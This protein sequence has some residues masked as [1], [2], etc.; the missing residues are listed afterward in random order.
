[1]EIKSIEGQVEIKNTRRLTMKKIRII[2]ILMLLVIVC[3]CEAN[4]IVFNVIR[5]PISDEIT[6]HSDLPDWPAVFLALVGVSF[7]ES[8]ILLIFLRDFRV[9]WACPY[10][11]AV[12]M[13]PG[14]LLLGKSGINASTSI[15]TQACIIICYF[16]ISVLIESSFIIAVVKKLPLRDTFICVLFAN[17]ITY[18]LIVAF[19]PLGFF[20]L[21][22]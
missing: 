18:L 14:F 5:K 21:N 22:I 13:I 19:A 2:V 11:N 4:P 3:V 20:Y 16:L 15:L 9:L 6:N 12:S 7:I 1:M 10:A 17:A 8:V